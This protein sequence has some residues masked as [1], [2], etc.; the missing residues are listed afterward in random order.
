MNEYITS[1]YISTATGLLGRG[2]LTGVYYAVT[3]SMDFPTRGQR[4][5]LFPTELRTCLRWRRCRWDGPMATEKVNMGHIGAI[6]A[7]E[8]GKG[9]CKSL[10]WPVRQ[11]YPRVPSR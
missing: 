6:L 7:I 10:K 1:L 8:R 11:R 9:I 4:R 3:K 2:G 5:S